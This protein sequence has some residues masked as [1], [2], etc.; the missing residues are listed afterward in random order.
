MEVE[1]LREAREPGERWMVGE[2]M[3]S[4]DGGVLDVVAFPLSVNVTSCLPLLLI[5]GYGGEAVF[6]SS[7]FFIQSMEDS[8]R[9][10]KRGH[11]PSFGR[12]RSTWRIFFFSLFLS[13]DS[14][15]P[16]GIF[17][18]FILSFIRDIGS[19]SKGWK[20]SSDV[21]STVARLC[22]AD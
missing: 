11:V 6:L 16:D 3:S 17:F 8:A 20:Y 22:S 4:G 18:P 12:L 19:Q 15:A 14:G 21:D 10:H 1:N 9:K 5:G 2:L 13:E 7:S